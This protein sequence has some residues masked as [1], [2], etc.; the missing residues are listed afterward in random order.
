MELSDPQKAT[1][2]AIA[3]DLHSKRRVAV[4]Q[5]LEK[6]G[7]VHLLES[8]WLLS[9]PKSAKQIRNELQNEAARED[10]VVV[11]ELKSRSLWSC[12]NAKYIGIS[13]LKQNITP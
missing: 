6:L 4:W 10:S 13:W 8:V 11:F 5:K 7:A 2:Y 12:L 1:C 9:S 3:C